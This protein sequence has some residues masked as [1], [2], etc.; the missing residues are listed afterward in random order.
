MDAYYTWEEI[1]HT[2]NRT[3]LRSG[4][5]REVCRSEDCRINVL[6]NPFIFLVRN[7]I[8]ENKTNSRKAIIVNVS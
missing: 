1:S 6:E 2:Q 3:V 5:G 4:N 7:W 8:V